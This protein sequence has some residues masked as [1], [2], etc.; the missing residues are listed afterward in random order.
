MLYETLDGIVKTAGLPTE[1]PENGTRVRAKSISFLPNAEPKLRRRYSRP[2]DFQFDDCQIF[3]INETPDL[4]V[5][6]PKQKS[7]PNPPPSK[8]ETKSDT[9]TFTEKLKSGKRRSSRLGNKVPDISNFPLLVTSPDEIV[10]ATRRKYSRAKSAPNLKVEQ[11]SDSKTENSSGS[12]ENV[13]DSEK[14]LSKNKIRVKKTNGSTS[15]T[16]SPTN[17]LSLTART[18]QVADSAN[19]REQRQL[20]RQLK[21][22]QSLQRMN[23]SSINKEKLFILQKS[24]A[25]SSMLYPDVFTGKKPKCTRKGKCFGTGNAD[26]GE[27][28]DSG[29]YLCDPSD[30]TSPYADPI[31]PKKR[32]ASKAWNNAI[33]MALKN[34][35]GC[36]SSATGLRRR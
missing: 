8:P 9:T 28:I 22:I 15:T 5:T 27:D 24:K 2:L 3:T 29:T 30:G 36:K 35:P 23:I 33:H 16:D 21:G 4:S 32:E 25:L 20:E 12:T 17:L 10:A 7:E 11:R 31:S 34:N 26:T 13:A 14:S 19:F 6:K 1:P 18:H